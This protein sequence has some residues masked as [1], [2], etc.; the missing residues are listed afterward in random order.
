MGQPMLVLQS[1]WV[2]DRSVADASWVASAGLKYKW[3]CGLCGSTDISRDYQLNTPLVWQS[4]TQGLHCSVPGAGETQHLSCSHTLWCSN[5]LFCD[6]TFIGAFLHIHCWQNMQTNTLTVLIHNRHS[7]G[8][9]IFCLFQTMCQILLCF[10][11]KHN[12]LQKKMVREI[13]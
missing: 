13:L 9:N 2:S 5:K 11:W 3:Q 6:S 12:F 10:E 4:V 8:S 7:Y 1:N